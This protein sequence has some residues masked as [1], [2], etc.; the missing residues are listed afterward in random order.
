MTL[1]SDLLPSVD[2]ILGVRDDIGA[3]LKP[4]SIVTRTWEGTEPGSGEAV[5]VA[6]SMLP[7]PR[8]V[9]LMNDYRVREGG[10]F[11]SG[12]IILKMVSKQSYANLAAVDCSTASANIEKFYS[13]GGILYRV[14]GVREKHL[15]WDVHLRRV[16][17]QSTYA[18]EE[19]P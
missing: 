14:I 13:V 3:A 19:E 11:Q 1:I 4:V 7:S 17:D 12:D 16:T 10:A 6:I 15:T 18:E 9:E 2:S 8:I 5:D